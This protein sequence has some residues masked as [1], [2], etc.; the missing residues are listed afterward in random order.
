MIKLKLALRK[1]FFVLCLLGIRWIFFNYF[2]S[3]EQV[4]FSQFFLT[5]LKVCLH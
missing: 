4:S 2:I 1:I 5:T 3:F